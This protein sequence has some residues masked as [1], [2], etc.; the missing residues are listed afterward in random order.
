MNGTIEP[1]ED[2]A[3]QDRRRRRRGGRALALLV[4]TAVV[5]YV[6]YLTSDHGGRCVMT[7]GEACDSSAPTAWTFGAFV[8]SAVLG[9]AAVAGPE[10]WARV[11]AV[12]GGIVTAQISAQAVMALLILS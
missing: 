8:V 9:L 11:R 4:P 3:E 12:R 7:G 6:L 10:G 2:P 1:A 5:C